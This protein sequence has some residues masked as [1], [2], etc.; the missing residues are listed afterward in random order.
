MALDSPVNRAVP[1]GPAAT[2][3]AATGAEELRAFAAWCATSPP[4]QSPDP[5]K[6]PT[7]GCALHGQDAAAGYRRLIDRA[8]LTV[9][10][11]DRPMGADEVA[12]LLS[13]FLVNG[14]GAWGGWGDLA[15]TLYAAQHGDL[16]GLGVM[17][18]ESNGSPGARYGRAVTCMSIP[19]PRGGYATLRALVG[20][21]RAIAPETGGESGPWDNA[22]GCAGWPVDEQVP[23]RTAHGVPPVLV[24]TTRH[25]LYSPEPMAGAVA[26]R[27]DRSASLGLDDHGHIAYLQSACVRRL[28]NEYLIDA[29]TPPPGTTCHKGDA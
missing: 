5:T 10:G 11:L 27:F 16:T 9:P 28:V 13:F 17:H 7:A 25:N 8:P 6:P 1:A 2:I 15:A 14:A 12:Q 20:V 18:R 3:G 29:R 4:Q 26:E 22:A 23:V 21:A 24:V 19:R